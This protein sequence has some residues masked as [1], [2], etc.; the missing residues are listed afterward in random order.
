MQI[1]MLP[2]STGYQLVI[3]ITCFKC[4]DCVL[5]RADFLVAFN[6]LTAVYWLSCVLSCSHRLSGFTYN[7]TKQLLLTCVVNILVVIKL[8]PIRLFY[9]G[10]L[11]SVL[12]LSI[13]NL[14]QLRYVPLFDDV[15]INWV[16]LLSLLWTL[17]T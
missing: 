9:C 8:K 5:T 12:F 7:H 15:I 6:L 13:T 3:H 16:T 10:I 11:F 14:C 1:L 2:A 17:F 4:H